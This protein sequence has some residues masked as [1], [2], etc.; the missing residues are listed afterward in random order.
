MSE[1]RPPSY[2]RPE[3]PFE[4]KAVVTGWE[5]SAVGFEFAV[6]V[7]LFFLGG[8][9]LDGKLGTEPLWSALGAL[10]G[11]A[12]GTYLLLRPV[13]RG[14]TR[15]TP[16]PTGERGPERTDAQNDGPSRDARP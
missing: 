5:W 2:Q 7:V 10:V 13:L 15:P 3:L 6:A 8:R 1:R 4:R 9:W 14:R 12:V 16:P 11:V